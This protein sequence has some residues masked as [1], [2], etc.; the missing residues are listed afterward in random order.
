MLI[1]YNIDTK[2]T[3]RVSE[4][5]ELE[6]HLLM[7]NAQ[8]RKTIDRLTLAAESLNNTIA[9][10]NQT[11]AELKEQ[12]NKN[13]RN[14]SKPPSSD[15]LKKPAPKSLR[16][17]SGKSAGGQK[18]HKGVNLAV[19]RKPDEVK[20]HMPKR[21]AGC[22]RYLTC[23]G[24]ACVAEVRHVV[25]AVV[26][27]K[28]TAHEA[29]EVACPMQNTILKGEIPND[30][31][32]HVQ[33]GENL[34][35]L[36]ISLNTVGA[37][38]VNR[39]HEILGSVFGIPLSTGTISNMVSRFSSR[40]AGTVEQIRQYVS[41]A[42]VGHFDETGLHINGKLQYAHVASNSAYTYLYL[43]RKRGCEAMDDGGILPVYH[44]VAVHDCWRSY[45]HYGTTHAVCCAHLLRELNGVKENHPQQTWAPA[46]AKLLLDM[47]AA[48]EQAIA[49]DRNSLE[50]DM[51]RAFAQRYD[52][53]LETGAR[54]NPLPEKTPGKRGRTKKGKVL[55]L[56]E[57]LREYKGAVCLFIENFAVP[58]DNNQAERDLRMIKVKAKVTG[59][60]RTEVGAQEYLKT[61]SYIGTARKQGVNPFV[62][63]SRA[64]LG[65]PRACWM[66][67][68]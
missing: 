25:D 34:Q 35:A 68:C 13:S 28:V 32:G 3:E 6:K 12:L 11:I 36:V 2:S 53:I 51:L 61:M 48:K 1:W 37:V 17:P 40:I 38:S 42:M 52:A 50:A 39:V 55:S 7:E 41:G 43:H 64:L 67:G 57:R 66:L 21:C 10:L 4:M 31:K 63:I 5:T 60:F 30:I 49:S 19:A 33:Y 23:L 46:F 56:I 20:H 8:L 45:W 15:G 29:L 58:F 59:G 62:A 27:V 14:S 44:G 9:S 16:K 47:K 24:S 18:G 54:E 65:E 22:P 26:D